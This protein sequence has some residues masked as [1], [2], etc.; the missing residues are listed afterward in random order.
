MKSRLDQVNS[1]LEQAEKELS[2]G[3][4]SQARLALNGAE[5]HWGNV[6]TML[7]KEIENL[8]IEITVYDL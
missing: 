8:G 5:R 2:A 1:S 3:N 4:A 7:K 6:E